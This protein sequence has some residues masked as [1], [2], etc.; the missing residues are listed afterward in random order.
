MRIY[1]RHFDK[2]AAY[3]T[4]PSLSD[5]G[6]NRITA[7]GVS[8]LKRYGAPLTIICSPYLQCQQMA[9]LLH[10][11]VLDNCGIKVG[12]RVD[13]LLS[14]YREGELTELT[15]L[16]DPPRGET[17]HQV[18]YRVRVHNDS[19][20]DF[21]RSCQPIWL[22]SHGSIITRLVTV[23]GFKYPQAVPML[24]LFCFYEKERKLQGWYKSGKKIRSL[25]R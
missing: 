17:Y 19:M 3:S 12:V 9:G 22:L 23:M 8:L 1:I 6:R 7:L 11:V 15:R 10:K 21:D 24:T 18:E 4:D 25:K 16:F 2:N 5:R 20:R 13:R 14:D